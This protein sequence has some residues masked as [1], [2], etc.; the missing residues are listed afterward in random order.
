MLSWLWARTGALPDDREESFSFQDAEGRTR[1]AW[2]RLEDAETGVAVPLSASRR[3]RQ[4]R[5]FSRNVGP[6]LG[7]LYL[8][9]GSIE[10]GAVAWHVVTG[11]T[12]EGPLAFQLRLA[13]MDG[14]ERFFTLSV[15]IDPPHEGDTSD[16]FPVSC[17]PR[18]CER[19][20]DGTF[21]F[22]L[23]LTAKTLNFPSIA[24]V[25][26]S[27]G[28]PA[29]PTP[30]AVPLPAQAVVL[31][32]CTGFLVA[33]EGTAFRDAADAL[34][35]LEL[36]ASGLFDDADDFEAMASSLARDADGAPRLEL[37]DGGGNAVLRLNPDPDLETS[38]NPADPSEGRPSRLRPNHAARLLAKA[39]AGKGDV[40]VW[41]IGEEDVCDY[42][43]NALRMADHPATWEEGILRPA[44]RLS[45]AESEFVSAL[46]RRLHADGR[47]VYVVDR[48][49]NAAPFS[50]FV[51]LP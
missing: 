29:A 15:R 6:N 4:G 34:A 44:V 11:P 26:L 22:R 17:E 23:A 43:G 48:S 42:A 37:G 36:R 33:P 39:L 19:A 49:A 24:T 9:T 8:Y 14:R 27:V 1:R 20:G 21:R 51:A 3:L 32:P 16:V 45:H 10:D 40:W 46:A 30:P 2:L 38:F 47:K 50:G 7:D 35:F 5:R 12:V 31:D 18:V 13:A 28:G 41:P 25:A